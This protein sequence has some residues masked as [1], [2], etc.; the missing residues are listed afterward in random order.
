MNWNI[1][2]TRGKESNSDSL[3]RGDW[4]GSSQS[5]YELQISIVVEFIWND[6]SKEGER[7]VYETKE[8]Q[9]TKS[10]AEHVEFCLN[11]N[12]DHLG[13]LNTN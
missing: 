10:R 12:E 3:S 13:R 11:N 6:K 8:T 1:L 2:V 5:A 9:L 7:P 4:K